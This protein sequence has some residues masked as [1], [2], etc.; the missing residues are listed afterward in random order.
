MIQEFR[1]AA[2]NGIHRRFCRWFLW[3]VILTVT[4]TDR[5]SAQEAVFE[6]PPGRSTVVAEGMPAPFS[7]TL[8]DRERTEWYLAVIDQRDDA[9]LR[10]E[11]CKKEAKVVEEVLVATE[12]TSRAIQKQIDDDRRRMA[13]GQV[14]AAV[15]I[16]AAF[17]GGLALG[18]SVTA[19]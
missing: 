7:G 10:Y 6:P 9:V 17:G 14:L 16:G 4:E 19:P 3:F 13:V 1:D 12:K 2:V 18:L 11:L 5:I 15:G 8:A